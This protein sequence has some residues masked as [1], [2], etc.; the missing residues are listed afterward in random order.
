MEFIE[1]WGLFGVN[2]IRGI[3]QRKRGAAVGDARET[4]RGVARLSVR[5][6]VCIRSAVAVGR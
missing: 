2:E 6:T 3:W 5:L 1:D 4:N